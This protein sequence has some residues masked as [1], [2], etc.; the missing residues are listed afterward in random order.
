MAAVSTNTY[1]QDFGAWTPIQE[2]RKEGFE[3][4]ESYDGVGGMRKPSATRPCPKDVIDTQFFVSSEKDFQNCE[5]RKKEIAKQTSINGSSSD[6][7]K[8][9]AFQNYS[10]PSLKSFAVPS[11]FGLKESDLPYPDM[12]SLQ[13]CWLKQSVTKDNW[14]EMLVDQKGQAA[15]YMTSMRYLNEGARAELY[16][17]AK[18][19]RL[20]GTDGN[21]KSPLS[22][23]FL[24]SEGYRHN[25]YYD[26]SL[27]SLKN[28]YD[29]IQSDQGC[30]KNEA[31]FKKQVQEKTEFYK[32]FSEL[33]EKQ[34][35][36]PKV[37]GKRSMGQSAVNIGGFSSGL[38]SN[39]A[40]VSYCTMDAST[41]EEFQKLEKEKMALW[42][43][44]TQGAAKISEK[45]FRSQDP[46][47]DDCTS[48]F[49]PRKIDASQVEP[50]LSELLK[51]SY[52]QQIRLRISRMNDYI[53][54]ARCINSED[55]LRGNTCMDNARSFLKSI[56]GFDAKSKKFG[57]KDESGKE[58]SGGRI[59]F[60]DPKLHF[61]KEVDDYSR[62]AQCEITNFSKRDEKYK[63]G[64]AIA[65]GA[66]GVV[67]GLATAGA[68]WF[69]AAADLTM[70]LSGCRDTF[71][72]SISGALKNA[73]K[74]STSERCSLD[75]MEGGGITSSANTL[76]VSACALGV[77]GSAAGLGNV[78]K[79]RAIKNAGPTTGPVSNLT[80]HEVNAIERAAINH[81]IDAA[82]KAGR[83]MS[84]E[85][86]AVLVKTQ[87][88]SIAE[89][90]NAVEKHSFFDQMAKRLAP[91]GD[92]YDYFKYLA[93]QSFDPTEMNTLEKALR[94]GKLSPT[95]EKRLLQIFD[96][97]LA[98]LDKLKSL[99]RTAAQQTSVAHLSKKALIERTDEEIAKEAEAAIESLGLKSEELGQ[100]Q[101]KAYQPISGQG[102]V[103]GTWT[104]SKNTAR[105]IY[106]GFAYVKNPLSKKLDQFSKWTRFQELK[107]GKTGQL[108]EKVGIKVGDKPGDVVAMGDLPVWLRTRFTQM[109]ELENKAT[110]LAAKNSALSPEEVKLLN[111]LRQQFKGYSNDTEFLR[112]KLI[113]QAKA[114]G[115]T[116]TV[117]AQHQ[118]ESIVEAYRRYQVLPFEGNQSGFRL[119]SWAGFPSDFHLFSNTSANMARRLNGFSLSSPSGAVSRRSFVLGSTM[120][121]API[122]YGA[123]SLMRSAMEAVGHEGAVAQSEA[124]V[125]RSLEQVGASPPE[126]QMLEYEK[127]IKS[128][129]E[130]CGPNK[131][132]RLSKF[133]G[134]YLQ[135]VKQTIDWKN[136]LKKRKG[137]FNPND[138]SEKQMTKVQE[139][140]EE[141][142]YYNESVLSLKSQFESLYGSGIFTAASEGHAANEHH[143][144][145]DVERFCRDPEL[146]PFFADKPNLGALKAALSKSGVLDRTRRVLAKLEA[147]EF[148]S[149][150]SE[151]RQ[152]YI[153]GLRSTVDEIEKSVNE[154]PGAKELDRNKWRNLSDMAYALHRRIPEPTKESKNMEE[155][156]D[157]YLGQRI[158]SS[159]N[160]EQEN[161][162][163]AAIQLEKSY[164][165]YKAAVGLDLS[166]QENQEKLK[167][168]NMN[169]IRSQSL[170]DANVFMEDL[171]TTKEPEA[172]PLYGERFKKL[173][174]SIAEAKKAY[175][176]TRNLA[177][178]DA[179]ALS[180]LG[181]D[182]QAVRVLRDASTIK[183]NTEFIRDI[184]SNKIKDGKLA[185][186]LV[187][188][189]SNLESHQA[190]IDAYQKD[191]SET[192][193]EALSHA[194]QEIGEEVFEEKQGLMSAIAKLPDESSDKQT[195]VSAIRNKS[196]DSREATDIDARTQSPPSIIPVADQGTGEKGPAGDA[197][198]SAEKV[199]G[200]NTPGESV[201]PAYRSERLPASTLKPTSTKPKFWLWGMIAALLAGIGILFGRRKKR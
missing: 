198:Q 147:E 105:F 23:R 50:L 126:I 99:A 47:V 7:L 59:A 74:T 38:H 88:T 182:M 104:G 40:Q 115:V 109:H 41:K 8:S 69:V 136:E 83:T 137:I 113:D 176:Q 156:F 146:F 82:A 21:T 42:A 31:L 144:E 5:A 32:A 164:G 30:Q 140:G 114:N 148:L 52:E 112:L 141:V 181:S 129:L 118:V 135:N 127:K 26:P 187:H 46:S 56:A 197:P 10:A 24:G 150:P 111:S 48:R 130:R 13:Q 160:S 14:K 170:L 123:D 143:V 134:Q 189:K 171:K 3:H 201:R 90:L 157:N 22:P 67:C 163:D 161:V 15:R 62:L 103:G 138:H 121:G 101:P 45:F 53:D 33:S 78:A 51:K 91:G 188:A 168:A 57:K 122:G 169:L 89:G 117:L 192:H 85:E 25:V 108:M 128:L 73:N 173:S 58:L 184:P 158:A 132:D 196:P 175:D 93:G 116:D 186:A 61:A 70:A 167:Q 153:T 12:K 100:L 155:R 75:S 131:S 81:E 66:A 107:F 120:V 84:P 180:S 145:G 142:R 162:K 165:E 86:A 72:K 98:E 43:G 1:A 68:C 110:R 178:L 139:F 199:G 20:V 166:S 35:K 6:P 106:N 96:G 9:A 151:E 4:N 152:Q 29:D 54:A 76:S 95:E 39:S 2:G 179:K 64:G 11:H 172:D 37:M 190:K 177:E 94:S 191:P 183:K 77:V 97:D 79:L 149:Q 16:E 63:T 193:L 28:A 44:I 119:P 195:I 71:Q 125:S 60:G 55:G 17:I 65:L 174:S 194:N 19:Q 27:P 36:L 185:S 34:A 18:L 159:K 154:A 80:A 92:K 200:A 124:D 133:V 87:Q 49:E 102:L